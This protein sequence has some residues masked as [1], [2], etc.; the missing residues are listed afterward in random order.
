MP[1]IWHF[2]LN[3]QTIPCLKK[4]EWLANSIYY[5]GIVLKLAKKEI[6]QNKE[7]SYVQGKVWI[8]SNPDQLFKLF[9]SVIQLSY[10]IQLFNSF[11]KLNPK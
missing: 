6:A 3:Y 11:S 8:S 10:S 1:S 5:F 4:Y 9:N 2:N 7:K